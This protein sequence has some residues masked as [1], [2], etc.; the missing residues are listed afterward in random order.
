MH[1]QCVSCG[2]DQF[3]CDSEERWEDAEPETLHCVECDSKQTS[4]GVGFAR[5]QDKSDGI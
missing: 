1:R 2:V 5:Y 4:V 3:I